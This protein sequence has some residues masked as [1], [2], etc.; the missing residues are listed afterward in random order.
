[1]SIPV[2]FRGSSTLSL[3]NLKVQNGEKSDLISQSTL[4]PPQATFE[5]H[6][7]I[8]KDKSY[9]RSGYKVNVL[10]ILFPLFW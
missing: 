7:D 10:I 1:M 3:L 5:V 8:F 6:L 4:M 2:I 9:C